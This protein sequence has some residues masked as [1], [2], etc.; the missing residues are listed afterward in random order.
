MTMVADATSNTAELPPPC[1]YRSVHTECRKDEDQHKWI[2][3]QHAGRDLGEEAIR[4][5]VRDHWHGYLRARWVEHLQGKQFWIELERCEFGLLRREFHDQK[6]LLD[7]ILDR[8]ARG[9]ENLLVICWA[10]DQG[11]DFDYVD[12]IINILTALDVNSSRL[13]HRS[14]VQPNIVAAS[15]PS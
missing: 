9:D 4:Q 10:V 6:A 5:W 15:I 12:R 8:L 3:S 11:F 2:E 13:L 14:E 1:E 7:N